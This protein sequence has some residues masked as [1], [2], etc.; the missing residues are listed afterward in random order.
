MAG[1][2]SHPLETM[3]AFQKRGFLCDATLVSAE[4]TVNMAHA[5]V[6]AASYFVL[7]HE[8][9]KCRQGRYT[10]V[11]S[12][13]AEEIKD[14]IKY[15]YT[16]QRE[17]SSMCT[18]TW[19]GLIGNA[20]RVESHQDRALAMMYKFSEYSL[21]SNMLFTTI[22][23]NVKCSMTY[24]MATQCDF[25]LQYIV[26]CSRV[27]VTLSNSLSRR[28]KN[29]VDN[30]VLTNIEEPV[31][32]DKL[33]LRNKRYYW[34]KNTVEYVMSKKVPRIT[35]IVKRLQIDDG[36]EF[37]AHCEQSTDKVSDVEES[38]RVCAILSKTFQARRRHI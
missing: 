23:K 17:M 20:F 2:P 16:G 9:Q 19:L 14:I 4:G 36:E 32:N 10:I 30:E 8:L 34:S 33:K 12:F 6:L 3:Y 5:G 18:F 22:N 15:A 24:M 28:V 26:T 1:K 38:C 13:S 35:Q 7:A 31:Q 37:Q 27:H 11:T 21:F 29:Y 25:L